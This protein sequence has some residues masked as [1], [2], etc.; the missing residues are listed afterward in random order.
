MK[1]LP[2]GFEK[3]DVFDKFQAYWDETEWEELELA[4]IEYFLKNYSKIPIPQNYNNE[5]VGTKFFKAVK[6]ELCPDYNEMNADV[7]IKLFNIAYEELGSNLMRKLKDS[8]VVDWISREN[9][10]ML[11]LPTERKMEDAKNRCD[12]NI[13]IALTGKIGIGLTCNTIDSVE[14]MRNILDSYHNPEKENLLSAMKKLDDTFTASVS[15]KIKESHFAQSPEYK[16]EMEL[17]SNQIDDKIIKNIFQI[18]DEIRKNGIKLMKS[19]GTSHPI[20]APTF[21]LAYSEFQMNEAIFRRKL[22]ELKPVF[23]TCLHVK[24]S[25]EL[26]KVKKIIEESQ[27]ILICK[28]CDKTF[29]ND[30]YILNKFCPKCRSLIMRVKKKY[31]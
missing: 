31:A 24:K 26:E 11:P 22:Q 9:W 14:K 5:S 3:R 21:E 20:E 29:T 2:I 19:R 23:E 15:R 25:R 12:P 4:K 7:Y 1:F 18:T 27:T 28:N 8:E 30:E 10:L 16:Q 13:Y 17:R 6:A